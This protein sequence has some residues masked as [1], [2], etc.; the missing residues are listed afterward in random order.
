MENQST[1]M[2][3]CPFCPYTICP[4]SLHC[5]MELDSQGQGWMDILDGFVCCFSQQILTSSTPSRML[6]QYVRQFCQ[7]LVCKWPMEPRE[8]SESR[9]APLSTLDLVILGVCRT[10]GA[11]VYVLI[12]VIIL[13]IAGPVIVICFLVVALSSVLSE[14]CYAKFWSCVP[15]SGSVYLYSVIV[16]GKLCAFIIDWNILLYLV[17]GEMMG[18]GMMWGL[19]SGN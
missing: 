11:G 7:G 14:L 5:S 3:T 10:L 9:R 12:G 16:M 1:E 2:R 13:L 18:R 4:S 6:R 15:H 17:A 19:R 8:E